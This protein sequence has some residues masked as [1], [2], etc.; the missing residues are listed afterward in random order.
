MANREK[1]LTVAA[2][3]IS[4]RGHHVPLAEIAEA[5]G[6]GVGT[7]YRGWPDRVALLHALE[8]RA[9][10]QLI[11]ILDRIEDAGQTGADAVETYLH[12]S[13]NLGNQLVLPLRGAPPLFDND[14]VAA[15]ARIFAAVERFLTDGK[16][17]G[18]VRV[19]VRASDVVY[20]AA[21]VTNPA[22]DT[23]ALQKLARRHIALFIHSIRSPTN[24]PL[25]EAAVTARDIEK[26]LSKRASRYSKPHN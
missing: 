5:A 2:E 6:V 19:D 23:P 8:H 14:A 9:Y 4:Q 21:Q 13:L 24:E 12:E 20:C 22:P 26:S 10:D 7:L 11:E 25:A 3:L 18:S 15:R 17:D 16:I 1:I